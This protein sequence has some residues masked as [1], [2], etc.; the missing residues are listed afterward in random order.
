[1]VKRTAL[2]RVLL[3]IAGIVLGYFI[4]IFVHGYLSDW[5]PEEGAISITPTQNAAAT[6]LPDSLVFL[7]WNV[8]FGGLG[9]ESDFFYDDEGMWYS[10][11]SMVRPPGRW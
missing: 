4:L 5:Q 2:R 9:A 7:T 6:P 3:A 1:M 10:G 11:S 8:G